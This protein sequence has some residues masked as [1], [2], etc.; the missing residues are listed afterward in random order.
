MSVDALCKNKLRH[1][2]PAALEQVLN[3]K[4]RGRIMDYMSAAITSESKRA[5]QRANSPPDAYLESFFAHFDPDG[6]D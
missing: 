6:R 4:R 2:Q 3:K 5:V 1:A